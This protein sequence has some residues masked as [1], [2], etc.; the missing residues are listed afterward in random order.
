MLFKKKKIQTKID[1]FNVFL[2]SLKIK[3]DIEKEGDET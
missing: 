3:D 1:K 2:F